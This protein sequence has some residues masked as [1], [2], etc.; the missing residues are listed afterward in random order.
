MSGMKQVS[1][2]TGMAAPTAE[3]VGGCRLRY[4]G[5]AQDLKTGIAIQE[6]A[7]EVIDMDPLHYDYDPGGLLVVGA[8]HQG[9]AVPFDHAF[10]G[11]VG[12]GVAGLKR[13][14]DDEEI[15]APAG[16]GSLD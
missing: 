13:I 7:N 4:R 5:Q 12:R 8:G 9:R 11:D 6:I 14:V 1:F 2:F 16:Q 15:S 3:I 10:A